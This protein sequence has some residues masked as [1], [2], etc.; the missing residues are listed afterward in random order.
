MVTKLF[1]SS[2]G[3]FTYCVVIVYLS[4]VIIP[5]IWIRYC[6]LVNI[7]SLLLYFHECCRHEWQ[8]GNRSRQ[9]ILPVHS[10]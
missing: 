3:H 10:V 2:L 4:V 8:C 9:V 5:G 6:V 7:M 1:T